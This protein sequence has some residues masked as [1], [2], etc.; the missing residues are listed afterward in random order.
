MYVCMYLCM[1]VCVHA[2]MHACMYMYI[3]DPPPL[4][5]T[6]VNFPQI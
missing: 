5:E 3:C 4:N 6:Q 2:C 1:Y